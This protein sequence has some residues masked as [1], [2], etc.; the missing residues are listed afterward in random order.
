[1]FI[2]T[3]KNTY[4]YHL[5]A[6]IDTSNATGSFNMIPPIT[7][8]QSNKINEI[9]MVD[10]LPRI[11]NQVPLP[12]LT[13][14][15]NV[16]TKKNAIIT[17]NGNPFTAAEGPY[18]VTGNPDWVTYIKNGV[19][20]NIKVLSDKPVTA[21]LIGGSIFT[22]YSGYYV[23]NSSCIKES[24]LSLTVCD[25]TQPI[26][27]T[28]TTSNQTINPNTVTIITPPQN[29]TAQINPITGVITYVP[30]NGYQGMDTIVY[31]FCGNDPSYPDCEQVTL[32]LTISKKPLVIDVTMQ[33]CSLEDNNSLAIFDLINAGITTEVGVV[34]KFYP[35]LADANA[36]TNEVLNANNYTAPNGFVYAVVTNAQGCFAISKITLIAV[37]PVT[38]SIL[39]DK[40]ICMNSTTTLD[41]GPGFTEY[42][43]STGATTSSIT[44]VMV[45]TYW[46]KLKT[47]RCWTKQN[48][49]VTPF[50][51]PIIT[52]I[53]INNNTITINADGGTK[54]YMYS[55]DGILWQD[56]D[57]FSNVPRG[58]A[59]VYIKDSNNC[60]VVS[61][62]TTVPNLINMITPNQDG[63]NDSLD[64]S[65]L[66]YK[67]NFSIGIYDRYGMKV[68]DAGKD[69]K[70]YSWSGQFAGRS[71]STG[72]YWYYVGW[73]ESNKN[74]TPIK[75]TGWLLVKNR[76]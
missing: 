62:E 21:E 2:R 24:T 60:G 11:S 57:I 28:F 37:P 67:D 13:T 27:P 75:Y 8:V 19:L 5:I 29:G 16:L 35:S 23:E 61:V 22:G 10:D 1:M 54:P 18:P 56:S 66:A 52:S 39:V 44:N 65:A 72:T 71:V 7:C 63:R 45:G 12:L 40:E 14:K 30:N 36:G 34:K 48:V 32:T 74:K 70:T 47:G 26:I 68:F 42:L 38:S 64:Y 76:E 33:S 46:V 4:V 55:L 50:N 6:G 31:S 25:N 58:K 17:V 41:A 43:W 73:T 15:L 3:S 9:P 49:K 59:I 51:E 53:E 20:G 69:S